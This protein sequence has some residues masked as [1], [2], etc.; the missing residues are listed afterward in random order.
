MTDEFEFLGAAH[1]NAVWNDLSVRV[2]DFMI[3][4]PMQRLC[5][6]VFRK[7]W[8][9]RLEISDACSLEHNNGCG[10]RTN[11]IEGLASCDTEAYGCQK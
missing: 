6:H 9:E 1:E 5:R 3:V 7:D 8:S 10:H 11:N 4:K 2:F